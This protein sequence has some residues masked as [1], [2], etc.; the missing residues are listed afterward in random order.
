MKLITMLVLVFLS[1]V[2]VDAMAETLTWVPP[3]T[4]A[5]GT[6][7][8]PATEIAEYQLTCGDTVT[9]IAPTMPEAGAY[10]LAKHEALPK[11]GTFDC[12][13]VAVDTDGLR[14]EPSNSVAVEWVKQPPMPPTN[15]IILRD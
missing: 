14:S 11:Y 9:T 13:M 1:I 5:D 3:T 6:P 4:R 10:E 15:L 2:A 8:D 7:L 12:T